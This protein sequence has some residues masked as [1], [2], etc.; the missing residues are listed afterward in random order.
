MK[1]KYD[2]SDAELHMKNNFS[3][4]ACNFQDILDV[5]VKDVEGG[6]NCFRPL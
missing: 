4:V 1:P 2:A 5:G 6:I 3:H